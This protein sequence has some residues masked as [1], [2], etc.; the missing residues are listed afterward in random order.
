[1]NLALSNICHF[2]RRK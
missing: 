1:M 2:V